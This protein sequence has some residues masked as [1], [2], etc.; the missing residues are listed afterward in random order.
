MQIGA[1]EWRSFPPQSTAPGGTDAGGEARQGPESPASRGIAPGLALGLLALAGGTLAVLLV[2]G[3]MLLEA[4]GPRTGFEVLAGTREPGGP[5]LLPGA[6]GHAAPAGPFAEDDVIVVDVSG[7]VAQPG[8]RRLRAGDRVGD[9][10]AAAGGFGPRAD[11]GA[12]ARSLNLAERL[13]DGQKVLVPALGEAHA[14]PLGGGAPDDGAS[15]AG[16]PG[17]TGLV[18]LNRASRAELES[19]P[20]IGPVTAGRIL[21]ARAAAAF[22]SVDELRARGLVGQSVFERVRPLVTVA[23]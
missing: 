17:G 6:G 19:L 10:I 21:D 4:S 13:Q 18:D 12:A 14:G 15:G 8:V 22:G 23:R 11:L 9:A 5:D 20:G 2:L 1:P 7:A 3:A 16:G